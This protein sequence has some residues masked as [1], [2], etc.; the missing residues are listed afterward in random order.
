[1][2]TSIEELASLPITTEYSN[3]IAISEIKKLLLYF[4]CQFL[5]YAF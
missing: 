5:H 2:L 1:M 4:T 3:S